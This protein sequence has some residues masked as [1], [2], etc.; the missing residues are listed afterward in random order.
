M[1]A[2]DGA[3]FAGFL[4]E[5]G[6]ETIGSASLEAPGLV[7]LAELSLMIAD[8]L[9]SLQSD[10]FALATLT[11]SALSPGT[12]ALDFARAFVGDAFGAHLSISPL[13]SGAVSV[14]PEPASRALLSLG[15]AGLAAGARR[16]SRG[17]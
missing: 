2:L 17:E 9:D 5:P 16:R 11:F 1:L 14:V 7:R 12:S 10:S 15:L 3:V 4:G 8:D 13:A 6:V